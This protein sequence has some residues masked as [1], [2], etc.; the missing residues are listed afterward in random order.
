MLDDGYRYFVELGPHPALVSSIKAVATTANIPVVAVGSLRRDE[1]GHD[2]MLRNLAQLYVSGYDPDW[3]KQF[4]EGTLLDLPT[5]A[6]EPDRHWLTPAQNTSVGG[7]SGRPF[8][9]L[10]IEASDEPDRHLV[11]AE[12]DLR[13]SRFAYLADHRIAGA[14]WLP[15]AAFVEMALEASALLHPSDAVRLSELR[16]ERALELRADE[17]VRLQ[18]V[19]QPPADDE[20]QAF[21]IASRPLSAD[22]RTAWTQ[23]VKGLIAPEEAGDVESAE[24]F[25]ALRDRCVDEVDISGL[26]AALAAAGV[27]Y[28]DAFQGLEAG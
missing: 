24:P 1:A 20:T 2:S 27:E 21:T 8:A 14:V 9:Q 6:F 23:H 19:V 15:A 11:Q 17:S 13:D 22:V 18:M 7:Q 12:I 3:S 5:Y 4:P 25:A 16:F 10:H 26:Y 28:R